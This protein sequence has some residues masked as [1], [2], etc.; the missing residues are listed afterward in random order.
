[1]PLSVRKWCVASSVILLAVATGVLLGSR[2]ADAQDGTGVVRLEVRY[3]DGSLVNDTNVCSEAQLAEYNGEIDRSY[4]AATYFQAG[5]RL[6][7]PSGPISQVRVPAGK[8]YV[9]LAFNC[10][11]PLFADFETAY[12][13]GPEVALGTSDNERAVHAVVVGNGE[14]VTFR[15]TVGRGI[16][17]GTH[18]DLPWCS[19]RA[20]GT[21]D[22]GIGEGEYA[23]RAGSGGTYSLNVPPG[24]YR[25]EMDCNE[26]KSNYPDGSTIAQTQYIQ[27]RH[28]Q[29]VSGVNFG[30]AFDGM[31]FEDRRFNVPDSSKYMSFCV[32]AVDLQGN[33]VY[34]SFVNQ[35]DLRDELENRAWFKTPTDRSYKLRTVD[36]RD[37]GIATSWYPGV[38][39]AADAT[40]LNTNDVFPDALPEVVDVVGA[41]LCNGEPATIIGGDQPNNFTGTPERDVIVSNGGADVIRGLGGDDVICAGGGNDRVFGNDGSDWIDAGPGHDWVGA[42]WGEDVVFGGSGNDF[43]RGFKH[44]DWIDGGS[45]NDRITGGWGNDVLRGGLGND[46]LRAYY[47]ADRLFGDAGNDALFAGNG[48]DFLVGGPGRADRLFGDQGR[49]ICNDVG[50]DSQFTDCESIN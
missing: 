22:G 30:P 3:P 35:L 25:V 43:I 31:R 16:I 40:V 48:P 38:A 39:N 2:S 28:G 46:T 18:P 11:S 9:G 42:G 23:R 45:G 50:V 1:M 20:I 49:D 24:R 8:P 5:F 34:R 29:T 21:P 14:T 10:S 6:D 47:G 37:L 26:V 36:C 33:L 12:H 15:I 32:D 44:N 19:A 17:T 13:F 4:T 41:A 27:V 7:E